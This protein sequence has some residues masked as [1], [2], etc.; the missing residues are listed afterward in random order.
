MLGFTHVISKKS[1]N[2]KSQRTATS[3]HKDVAASHKN[4]LQIIAFNKWDWR[5]FPNWG[6][7]WSSGLVIAV[8]VNWFL[9]IFG[10]EWIKVFCA[11][12][13]TKGCDFS[14]KDQVIIC[15]VF[16]T[17]DHCAWKY[18]SDWQ[19]LKPGTIAS[20]VTA[21]KGWKLELWIVSSNSE[22]MCFSVENITV[23]SNCLEF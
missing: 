16:E 5:V 11:L 6:W 21:I 20:A 15:C 14:V 10:N 2:S 7:F 17:S 12:P 8:T 3:K 13:W 1:F 9:V 18:L 19:I 23:W 4:R 22:K